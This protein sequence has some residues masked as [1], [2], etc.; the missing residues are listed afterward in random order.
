MEFI[1]CESLLCKSSG[2]RT[3]NAGRHAGVHDV[4]NVSFTFFLQLLTAADNK[5]KYSKPPRLNKISPDILNLRYFFFNR[6]REHRRRE[7]EMRMKIAGLL[8]FCLFLCGCFSMGSQPVSKES[9]GRAPDFT[10][11]DQDGNPVILSETAKSHRGVVVAF[12]PKDD[13]RN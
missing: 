11:P 7:T 10:L 5:L 2:A 3:H 1:P 8:V 4:M 6:R 9:E 13:T 12:Y